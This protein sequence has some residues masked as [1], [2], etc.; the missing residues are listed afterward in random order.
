[1]VR[2]VIRLFGDGE[3]ISI[4]KYRI[5]LNLSSIKKGFGLSGLFGLSRS[6]GLFGLFRLDGF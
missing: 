1:M 3:F 6:S 2:L 5:I 4:G